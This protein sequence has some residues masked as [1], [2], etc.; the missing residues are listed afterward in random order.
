[1]IEIHY[2]EEFSR[3]YGELPVV[4]QKKAER[5]KKLFRQNPFHPSLKTEKLQP[6]EKNTGVSVWTGTTGSFSDS[7]K[8]TRFIL[9]LAGTISGF[10]ASA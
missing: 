8:A 7:E 3:R 10:A 1:M 6:L 5:R 2:T 9:L 4:I